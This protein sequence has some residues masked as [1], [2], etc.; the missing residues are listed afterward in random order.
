LLPRLGGQ[1][2]AAGLERS[3][4]PLRPG[5]HATGCDTAA[6]VDDTGEGRRLSAKTIATVLL[7]LALVALFVFIA[8]AAI[9]SAAASDRYGR[10]PMP[11]TEEVELPEGEVIVSYEEQTDLEENES[12]EVPGGIRFGVHAEDGPPLPI[13]GK[14]FGSQTEDD[15]GARREFAT[16]EVPEEGHYVVTVGPPPIEAPEPAITFGD[17]TFEVFLRE[18]KPALYTALPLA[19]LALIV[20]VA[21]WVRRRVT[22]EEKGPTLPPSI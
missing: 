4:R 21:A 8:V 18:V 5:G 22:V 2:T 20:L 3:F 19:G 11:G 14:R 12:L 7:V 6:A 9:K 16:L 13:E 17:D 1:K 10:V 15:D